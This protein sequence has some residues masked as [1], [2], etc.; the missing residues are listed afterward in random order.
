MSGFVYFVRCLDRVKIGFSVDPKSRL[1]KI[2][3]DA[4]FPCEMLG[5]V[6]VDQFSE[7][8]LHTRF[9]SL[10]I[11]GEWFL[12]ASDLLAFIADAS[13][14]P[15]PVAAVKR[16]AVVAP[17]PA[18]QAKPHPLYDEIEGFLKLTGMGET[19]LGKRAAN[20]SAFVARLRAGT[21]PG[22]R[23][24]FVRPAVETAVRDFMRETLTQRKIAA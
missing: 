19:Y 10:R 12:A 3:A 14:S 18:S 23:E 4:P 11:H 16:R 13:G 15:Q 5:V 1:V 8:D 6:P 21:T 17:R 20:D 7:A 9:S 22:G 2:N 24:V